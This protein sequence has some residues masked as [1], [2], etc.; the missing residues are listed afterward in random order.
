[1]AAPVKKETMGAVT[2]ED[3]LQRIVSAYNEAVYEKED[4][5][6]GEWFLVASPW[7]I[8]GL[9]AAYLLLVVKILPK[10][11]ENRK[12]FSL[13]GTL[14]LVNAFQI[15]ANAWIVYEML[16]SGWAKHYNIL[17]QK[18]DYSRNPLSVRMATAV[19]YFFLIKIFD[20]SDTVFFVLRK[21]SNQVTFLHLFHHVT[22]LWLAWIV[23]KYAP[24][25]T[26]TFAQMLNAVVHVLMYG[27]YLLSAMGSWIRPYLWWKK[28]LTTI[29]MIQF[30]VTWS[31]NFYGLITDCGYS[32]PIVLTFLPIV[33]MDFI[34][35]YNFYYHSYMA[36]GK[37][38]GED[39]AKKRVKGE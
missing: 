7:P 19:Y 12:P 10:Y 6:T 8:I 21:K 23:V 22:T 20:F 30:I 15:V 39:D 4:P 29:Q 14:V 38:K 27:Y 35:F 28:Y 33:L 1:M 13:R 34:L 9:M 16:A 37:L 24:G 31:Q 2:E 36:K 25:G 5:R 17:C 18:V 3:I 11:M 26:G 32:K